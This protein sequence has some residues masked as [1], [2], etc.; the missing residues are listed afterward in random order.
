MSFRLV[1]DGTCD[2]SHAVALERDIPVIPFKVS[3]GNEDFRPYNGDPGLKNTFSIG[4]FYARMRAQENTH[5]S[6]INPEDYI[7]YFTPML[8]A[9]E[10]VLYLA[11]SSGLSGSCQ[12]AMLAARELEEKYPGRRLEVVDTLCASLGEGLLVCSLATIALGRRNS[13]MP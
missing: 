13:G 8:E 7:R 3:V 6:Q 11:F 4:E 2:L 5:T 1:T 12:N 10:D 9:G